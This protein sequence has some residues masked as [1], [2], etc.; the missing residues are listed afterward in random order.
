MGRLRPRGRPIRTGGPHDPQLSPGH[1]VPSRENG[2]PLAPVLDVDG[3][4][5]T[6][7]QDVSPRSDPVRGSPRPPDTGSHDPT[8]ARVPHPRPLRPVDTGCASAHLK[9]VNSR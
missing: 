2:Q 6:V 4:A 5:R 9:G 7:G 8:P 1:P 3:C